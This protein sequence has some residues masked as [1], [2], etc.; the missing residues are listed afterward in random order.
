MSRL[1][2]GGDSTWGAFRDKARDIAFITVA[3]CY[4]EWFGLVDLYS[5]FAK[6]VFEDLKVILDDSD[7][8]KGIWIVGF[9]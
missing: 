1:L 3:E 2:G 5:P 8:I 9:E 4:I 6:P 7:C